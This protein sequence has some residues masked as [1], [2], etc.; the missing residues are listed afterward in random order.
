MSFSSTGPTTPGNIPPSDIYVQIDVRT[1]EEQF[2]ILPRQM[3]LASTRAATRT[4]DW[5]MTQLTRELAARTAIPEKGLK[6]RFRRGGRPADKAYSNSGYAVLW[7]GLNAME[8]QK[9]GKVY[10]NDVGTIAGN[11]FFDR[12]FIAEIYSGEP[13]VWRRKT[14]GHGSQRFPVVK[15]TVPIN[16]ALEE[17]LP[18]YEAAAARM[19]SSRLQHELRFL[20]DR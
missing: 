3:A 20:M 13:K 4:R 5:L 1:M 16:E 7:I 8:A 17:I 12:A 18:S 6:R 19:F 15:M 2:K 11:H 10:Q 14:P 9:L